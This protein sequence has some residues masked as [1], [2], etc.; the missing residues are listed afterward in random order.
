MNLLNK[1]ILIVSMVTL[2][3]LSFSASV[4][5]ATFG[6]SVSAVGN[7]AVANSNSALDLSTSITDTKIFDFTATNN[8]PDGFSISFESANGGQLRHSAYYN[9]AKTSS[10]IDY[11]IDIVENGGSLGSTVQTGTSM[12]GVDLSTAKAVQYNEGVS[13]ATVAAV[14]DIKINTTQKDLFSGSYND[15]ITVTIADL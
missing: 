15:T 11:T 1:T 9:N 10:F 8:D 6:G 7:V 4:G 5:S 13:D 14:W 2:T 3:S 12:T